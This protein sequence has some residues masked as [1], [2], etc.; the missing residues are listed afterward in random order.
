MQIIFII[1]LKVKI[2][3]E[4]QQMFGFLTQSIERHLKTWNIELDINAFFCMEKGSVEM[5]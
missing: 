2:C 4:H 5:S 1:F 3:I